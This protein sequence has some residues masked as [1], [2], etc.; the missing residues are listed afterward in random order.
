[1]Q[2]HPGGLAAVLHCLHEQNG[3]SCY[4]GFESDLPQCYSSLNEHLIVILLRIRRIVFRLSKYINNVCLYNSEAA[5]FCSSSGNSTARDS[6]S[7]MR[8]HVGKLLTRSA[9]EPA[10]HFAVGTWMCLSTWVHLHRA[11]VID[12]HL[13]PSGNPHLGAGCVWVTALAT[14]KTFCFCSEG[15]HKGKDQPVCA[16]TVQNISSKCAGHKHN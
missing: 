11:A 8:L 16:I 13:S 4:G 1:M 5:E 9:P 14:H 3:D 12:L 10:E 7:L 2:H 15:S 6:G